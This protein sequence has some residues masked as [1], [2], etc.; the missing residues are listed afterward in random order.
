VVDYLHQTL[1]S[2]YEELSSISTSTLNPSTISLRHTAEDLLL[3]H[4]VYKCLVI[5]ATWVWH[6]IDLVKEE[7]PRL[8]P[9]V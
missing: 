5:M 2:Y 4:L 7:A 6:R 9:W 3:A 1:Y 8:E